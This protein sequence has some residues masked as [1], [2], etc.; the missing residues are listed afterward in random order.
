MQQDKLLPA[1]KRGENVEW[2][3]VLP[4]EHIHVDEVCRQIARLIPTFSGPDFRS[5]T[6]KLANGIARTPEELRN[7]AASY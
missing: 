2:K 6:M 5:F 3:N 7:V 1:V 4:F